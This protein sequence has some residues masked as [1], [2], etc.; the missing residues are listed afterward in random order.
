MCADALMR[1]KK[2]PSGGIDDRSKL[3]VTIGHNSYAAPSLSSSYLSGTDQASF[4]NIKYIFGISEFVIAD[5]LS[6][7]NGYFIP[8][9]LLQL[10]DIVYYPT[11]L[12]SGEMH[13]AGAGCVAP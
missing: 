13:P 11:A 3:P 7:I 10:R 8:G 6:Y 12:A 1:L 9:C 2:T 5:R 4:S